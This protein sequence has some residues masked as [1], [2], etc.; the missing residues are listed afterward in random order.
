M[1]EVVNLLPTINHTC[2]LIKKAF[3]AVFCDNI[4]KQNQP[5][6]KKAVTHYPSSYRNNERHVK[7]DAFLSKILFEQIR[8]YIPTTIEPNAISPQEL[9]EWE[10]EK[11]NPRLRLCRYLPNQ[12]FN[13]HLDGIHYESAA[14]QSKLTFM[15]YLNGSESFEGGRTLFFKSQTDT[16]ITQA[17]TPEKGD[18]II[19][20]HNIWH[21]G[22]TVWSGE[23]YILRSDILYKRKQPFKNSNIYPF[24]Q[25]HLG[26]IWTIEKIQDY[27]LTGGRDKTIKMWNGVGRLLFTQKCH[28]NSILA[29]LNLNEKFFISASRDCF[30]KLWWVDQD[31]FH[32]YKKI[33]IHNGAVLCLGKLNNSQFLS[34]GADGMINKISAEGELLASFKAHNEWI[35]DVEILDQNTVVSIGED[36]KIKIW[37]LTQQRLITLWQDNAPINSI[38]KIADSDLLIGNSK[39][40]ISLL[41]YDKEGEK[42]IFKKS[43]IAHQGIIRQIKQK[44]SL[45]VSGGEDSKVRIWNKELELIKEYQHKN[46]VQDVIFEKDSIIS[47]SYDG[48]INQFDCSLT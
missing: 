36:G 13:K 33:K 25:G 31:R 26:Y 23:K 44:N 8:Q 48:Q 1:R 5:H 47:V 39:G 3:D 24:Q 16:T 37:E 14:I 12:Y 29:L 41:T 4:I 17:Y 2:I 40:I 35:W 21:S 38:C 42:L 30:I 15:I 27:F 20:D 28:D 22:E 9:G 10:L 6:Y 7:D 18:L 46:F 43:R 11:L 45:I 34:A 19:F 32:F